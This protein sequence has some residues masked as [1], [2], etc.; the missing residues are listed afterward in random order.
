MAG[1]TQPDNETQANTTARTQFRQLAHR[2]KDFT[3][4]YTDIP[5]AGG[6]ERRDTERHTTAKV[7]HGQRHRADRRRSR[8][9]TGCV[10]P[11]HRGP[12]QTRA[13]STT[14]EPPLSRDELHRQRE[15]V[16]T[17]HPGTVLDEGGYLDIRTDATWDEAPQIVG[18]LVT[19]REQHAGDLGGRRSERD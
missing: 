5:D 14:N 7:R 10:V 1:T 11:C 12:T 18:R 3:N 19:A 6:R 8:G 17:R 4:R 13:K 15:H 16:K 2:V 9:E